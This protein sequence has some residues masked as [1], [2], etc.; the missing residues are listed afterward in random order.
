MDIENIFPSIKEAHAY[1]KHGKYAL[2]LQVY[3]D[4]LDDVEEDSE[5]YAYILLEYAQCLVENVMQ[6]AE[7]NYKRIL[8]TRNAEDDVDLE[9]DLENCWN[10]LET[11]RLHFGDLENRPKLAEVHKGLGDVQCLKNCFE[12]GKLEYFKAIDYCDDDLLISELLECVA[13][14]YRNM[15]MYDEAIDYYKQVVKTYEQLGMKKEAE[16]YN[17]LIDGIKV[18]AA[19][20]D[21]ES[22]ATQEPD[23]EAVDVN[24]LK[25][26]K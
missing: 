24:H 1:V 10:C 25:R 12:D 19:Q 15:K 3:I 11:C 26:S 22:V 18:I 16:E 8:Q 20:D 21:D 7:M 13:D 6:Q 4:I 17:S 2:A 14:C 9:E 5:E 23:G